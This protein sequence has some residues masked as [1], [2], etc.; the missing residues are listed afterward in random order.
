MNP[1]SLPL[2]NGL[3]ILWLALGWWP[4]SAFAQGNSAPLLT[5]INNPTPAENGFFGCAV[6]AV[7]RDCVLVGAQDVGKAYL[8]TLNGTLLT[9]FTNRGLG[10]SLAAVGSDRVLIGTGG[11]GGPY[12]FATNGTLL[13]T[14][15][16]PAP[17]TIKEFGIFV[18]AVG[19]DRVVIVG[20]TD[21]NQPR[22]YPGSVCLFNT[23][24]TL[25]T[26]FPNPAPADPGGYGVVAAAVG[27]DRLLLGAP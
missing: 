17:A 22:P 12:L 21:P 14:F 19:S 16:N 20:L 15:T 26:T 8:F 23:N 18:A 13:T 4:G 3:I 7:G 10:V 6:A 24:G 11:G 27:S 2:G 5:T 25:L 1:A 9:T